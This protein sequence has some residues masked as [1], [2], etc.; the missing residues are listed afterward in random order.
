MHIMHRK[1]DNM[2]NFE[3]LIAVIERTRLSKEFDSSLLKGIENKKD[4]DKNNQVSRIQ[5]DGKINVLGKKVYPRAFRTQDEVTDKVKNDVTVDGN[6]SMW[7]KTIAQ[8]NKQK[9]RDLYAGKRKRKSHITRELDKKLHR[10]S[11]NDLKLEI[12]E[13]CYHGDISEDERNTLLAFI[14]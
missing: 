8:E 5:T 12:Y 14:D 4:T 1:G 13:S 3:E 7:N 11:V 6:P 10:E 2:A 9:I